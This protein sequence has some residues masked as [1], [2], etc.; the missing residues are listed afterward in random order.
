MILNLLALAP[1]F[2]ASSDMLPS[3]TPELPLAPISA[4]LSFKPFKDWTILLPNEQFKRVGEGISFS[5]AG[6]DKFAVKLEG[7]VLWVDRDGDG[8]CEAKVEPLERGKTGLMVFRGKLE[9]GEE[10]SYAVRLASAGTWSYSASGAMVGELAGQRIALIDQNNN[11]RFDDYGADA[12]IV[13]RGKAASFLSRTVNL[14]GELYSI[15][16]SADGSHV[17]ATKYEGASGTI[18]LA[19]ALE[20]KARMRSIVLMSTDGETSFE[21]SQAKGAVKVPIGDYKVHSGQVALGKGRADLAT[22]RM[23]RVTV[24][25]DE[26]VSL[27]WGGPVKAEFLFHR[28]GDEITIGPREIWYYG[29]SGEVYSNFM[30]LG[31][32]P[33]FAI[34]DKQTGEVLVNAKFPGNC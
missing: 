20:T 1:C 16:V 17:D 19:S 27:E 26:N 9:N 2:T 5:H 3:A 21:V 22:G 34:K 23:K 10:R 7:T 25:T 6:G 33:T 13:G 24:A 31:S 4:D 32:S 29:Q 8:E 12:M 11:G 15:E 30:P 14:D 28:K 18:D